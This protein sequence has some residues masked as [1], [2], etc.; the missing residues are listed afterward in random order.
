M[1]FSACWGKKSFGKNE[2]DKH[3]FHTR[4]GVWAQLC[5][6]FQVTWLVQGSDFVLASA[7]AWHAPP[8]CGEFLESIKL[9]WICSWAACLCHCKTDMFLYYKGQGVWFALTWLRVVCENQYFFVINF[10]S[11]RSYDVEVSYLPSPFPEHH[12]RDNTRCRTG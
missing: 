8:T 10:Y 3:F 12:P 6:G 11:W 9:Q 7:I 5:R 4:L 2:T 1:W